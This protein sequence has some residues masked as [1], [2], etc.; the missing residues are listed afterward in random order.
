MSDQ[1]ETS[2]D[3]FVYSNLLRPT[4]GS[5]T[6]LKAENISADQTAILRFS[7]ATVRRTIHSD[8]DAHRA[9]SGRHENTPPP[10]AEPGGVLVPRSTCH[11]GQQ[12]WT[13]AIV[14]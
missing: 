6:P 8:I 12:V 11:A 10:R 1:V 14:H 3:D 13:A 5:L 7:L 9:L 4:K 2:T